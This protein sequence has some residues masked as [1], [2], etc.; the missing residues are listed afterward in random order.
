[1]DDFSDFDAVFGFNSNLAY[2]RGT[3]DIILQHR[4]KLEHELFIDRLLKALGVRKVSKCYPPESNQDL[5]S[6]HKQITDSSS[7]DHYKHSVLYYIIKDL[8]PSSSDAPDDFAR[9]SYLPDKYKIFIDG[10]WFLDRLKFEKALDYLTEPALIPTFPEEILYTLCRHSSTDITLPMAYYHTVSPT[11]TSSKVLEAY[12]LVLCRVS[13]T[14]AFFFSRAQGEL[15]H[16]V[17]FEKLISFVHEKSKGANKAAIGVELISLPFD[18][19]EESWFEDF[20]DEGKGGTLPGA[21]DTLTM[22]RIATGRADAK[23]QNR[24]H[25]SSQTIDG[26]NWQTLK[27]GLEDE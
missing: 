26:V 16:R 24:R 20:L 9:A 18:E 19:E 10:I 22:R 5:R 4:Q 6:L 12:F 23:S 21:V 15:N 2:S 27:R 8:S 11:I 1:M 7:P 14:E 25:G 17:L 13:V 3:R